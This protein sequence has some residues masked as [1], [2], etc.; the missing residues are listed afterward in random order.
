MN[1][2]EFENKLHQDQLSDDDRKAMSEHAARC[3]ACRLKQDLKAMM[4]RDEIPKKASDGWRTAVKEEADGQKIRKF[5]V[6]ARYASLAAC[7]V[8]LVFGAARV[9][10][11]DLSSTVVIRNG[12]KTESVPEA[13]AAAQDTYGAAL[14]SSNR[15]V[16]KSADFSNYAAMEEPAEY[17][18]YEEAADYDAENGAQPAPEPEERAEKIVRN[19][20]VS[21]TTP[22]F[23]TDLQLIQ[24]SVRSLNGRIAASTT[25]QRSAASRRAYLTVQIPAENLDAYLESIGGISGRVTRKEI[26][27]E[28]ITEQYYDTRARLDNAIVKR[29]RLKELLNKAEDVSDLLEIENNLSETQATIDYLTGRIRSFDTRVAYSTV[30][31]TLTEETPAQ[32]VTEKDNSFFSRLRNGLRYSFESI[33]AFLQNIFLFLLIA[34]PWLAI[35]ALIGLSVYLV[36]KRR[37]RKEHSK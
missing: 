22:R 24:D 12:Q 5:P 19:A 18:S 25:E 8:I 26:S 37:K 9:G 15:S 6:W 34:L 28:N 11:M 31:I 10:D 29:D 36:L 17:E 32:S 3:S 14:Y 4:P 33:W 30:T 21:I 23:E 1:C 16:S 35:A 7:L 2:E 20:T 13:P 27:S